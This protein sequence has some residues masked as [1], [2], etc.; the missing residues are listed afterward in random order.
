[1]RVKTVLKLMDVRT[2]VASFIPVTYGSVLS[3]YMKGRFSVV[4]LMLMLLGMILIQS[5]ANMLNDYADY[6]REA[7]TESK[8]E[9][10][11]L[12]NGEMSAKNVLMLLILYILMAFTIGIY[13]ACCT[14]WW[15]LAVILA[16]TLVVILY[17][18]GPYPIC[19][20]PFGELAAGFSMGM[21]VVCSVFY[22]Q[23]GFIDLKVIIAGIPTFIFVAMI[24]MSNN[25][26]DWIEDKQAG[27]KT[28][29]ILIGTKKAEKIWLAM[30]VFMYATGVLLCLLKVFPLVLILVLLAVFP[31]KVF[32]TFIDTPKTNK[33][34]PLIMKFSAVSGIRFHVSTMITLIFLGLFR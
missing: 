4:Y 29:V 2:L 3:W 12:V 15:I 18:T 25:L 7:D 9:E 5:A 14:S 33:Y 21:V 10:K 24:L 6:K 11:V 16:G 22:I 23:A 20:T 26:S 8:G 30:F 31:Y 1:M 13:L 32:K 17:S 19:Y 28:L 27:R 34:K